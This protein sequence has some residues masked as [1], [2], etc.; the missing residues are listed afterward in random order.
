VRQVFADR[1]PTRAAIEAG[2]PQG[3]EVVMG[4]LEGMHF[5]L[6]PKRVFV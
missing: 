2:K 4:P 5:N 3:W 6:F 1:Y